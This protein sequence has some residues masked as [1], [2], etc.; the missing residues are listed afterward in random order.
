MGRM[1]SSAPKVRWSGVGA[2]REKRSSISPWFKM[3]GRYMLKVWFSFRSCK[4]LNGPMPQLEATARMRF[5]K[6]PNQK[7]IRPPMEWPAIPMRLLST[8]GKAVRT[9]RPRE[10]S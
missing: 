1:W 9:A 7:A 10:R 6:R 4:I 5:S 2:R 8:E 3:P